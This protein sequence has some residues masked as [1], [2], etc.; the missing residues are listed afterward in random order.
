MLQLL[1]RLAAF[2]VFSAGAKGDLLLGGVSG[3]W[4]WR[5]SIRLSRQ[6][7]VWED[8]ERALDCAVLVLL[9]LLSAQPAR[10]ERR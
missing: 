8:L 9:I 2:L 10:C 3:A 4:P 1:L 5:G 7:T 6:V